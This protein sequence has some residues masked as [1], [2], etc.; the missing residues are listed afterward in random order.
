MRKGS[1]GFPKLAHITAHIGN[2]YFVQPTGV[3]R[4]QSGVMIP[5]A[6]LA[7][8]RADRGH[9]YW[10]LLKPCW[11]EHQRA[12]APQAGGSAAAHADRSSEMT[13]CQGKAKRTRDRGVS[14][15]N[16]V[17]FVF[18]T[19]QEAMHLYQRVSMGEQKITERTKLI[20][21]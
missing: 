2:L 4:H 16:E 6:P 13:G 15:L 10:G 7:T 17:I 12:R 1:Y 18:P 20:Q 19:I 3:H 14:R 5:G 21:V 8:L 11:V 9:Q